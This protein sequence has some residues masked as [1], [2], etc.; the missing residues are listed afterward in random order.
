MFRLCCLIFF[1]SAGCKV[2]KDFRQPFLL[3][4]SEE[5]ELY[6]ARGK[7]R[8]GEGFVDEEGISCNTKEK[9]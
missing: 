8:G 4:V 2:L 9:M 7:G 6:I 5:F 3:V 1:K